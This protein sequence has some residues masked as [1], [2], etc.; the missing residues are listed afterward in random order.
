MS[1]APPKPPPELEALDYFVGIWSCTGRL[2][3]TA[4][5]PARKTQ[6][7][8]DL[9]LELGKHFL[10]VAEDDD[11]SLEQ[12]RRRQLRAYW[13]YDAG[14]EALHVRV[15]LLRGRPL[16]R[17]VAGMARRRPDVLGRDVRGRRAFRDAEGLPTTRA[18]QTSPSA[19]TSSGP[20]AIARD[21]LEETCTRQGDDEAS[22]SRSLGDGRFPRSARRS[23]HAA[24]AP[25]RAPCRSDRWRRIPPPRRP[26]ESRPPRRP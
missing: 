2:E 9:P 7:I 11:L 26:G 21:A 25:A 23:C 10:G 1:A 3:A 18:T 6:G 4:D 16:H 17:N 5:A 22:V 15:V 20:T 13:G 12:P 19:S 14:R 8:H 24:A